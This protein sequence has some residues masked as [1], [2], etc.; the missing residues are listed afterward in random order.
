ME[1]ERRTR[2]RGEGRTTGADGSRR[3]IEGRAEGSEEW[4]KFETLVP[5]RERVPTGQAMAYGYR[6]RHKEMNIDK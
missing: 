6:S 4:G 1:S 2:E 5:Q 3:R